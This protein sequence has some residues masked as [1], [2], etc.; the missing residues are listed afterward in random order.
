MV[1]FGQLSPHMPVTE[2]RCMS[3]CG[4]KRM[5]AHS[6]FAAMPREKQ[7]G[8]KSGRDR[9]F[10]MTEVFAYLRWRGRLPPPA[11]DCED[12]YAQI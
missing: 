6:L 8:W 7:A 10:G 1:L 2:C 5:E 9:C 3:P 4:E 11:G 12:Q